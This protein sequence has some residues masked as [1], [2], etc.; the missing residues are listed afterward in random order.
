MKY[1]ANSHYSHTTLA[2]RPPIQTSP[3]KKDEP[4]AALAITFKEWWGGGGGMGGGKSYR[5]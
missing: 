3:N 2:R 1:A 4:L 5:E